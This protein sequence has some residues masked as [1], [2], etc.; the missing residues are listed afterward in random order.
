MMLG[1]GVLDRVPGEQCLHTKN[2][3]EQLEELQVLQVRE[4]L[5]GEPS[6]EDPEGSTAWKHEGRGEQTRRKW[7]GRWWC[8]LLFIHL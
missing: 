6:Q 1:K 2:N 4:P 3:A 5:L 7:R 8:H